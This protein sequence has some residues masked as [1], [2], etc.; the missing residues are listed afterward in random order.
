M[1]IGG[2]GMGIGLI[3]LVVSA[4]Q[5]SEQASIC[6]TVSG[7]SFYKIGILHIQI[8]LFDHSSEC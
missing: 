8:V 4:I 2:A 7:Y 5:G 3:A 1:I 6:K